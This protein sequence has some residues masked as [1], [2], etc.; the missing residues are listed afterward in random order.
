MQFLWNNRVLG[1][2]RYRGTRNVC[3]IQPPTGARSASAQ[4]SVPNYYAP[5]LQMTT[6]PAHGPRDIRKRAIHRCG[7]RENKIP[8]PWGAHSS[9]FRV[10]V[11]I[12]WLNTAHS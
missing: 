1:R 9:A 10:L 5:P 3:A 6:E 2:Y 8:T 4:R 11:L 12:Q 7:D